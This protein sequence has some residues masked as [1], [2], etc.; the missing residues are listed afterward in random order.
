MNKIE[1]AG[2]IAMVSEI[3]EE[4][5]AGY[6]EHNQKMQEKRDDPLSLQWHSGNKAALLPQ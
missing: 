3:E 2:V 6:A 5:A 1:K 4:C